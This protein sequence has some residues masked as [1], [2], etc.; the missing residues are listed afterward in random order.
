MT[1]LQELI[2]VVRSWL[3]LDEEIY[4]DHV[5]TSWIRMAEEYL[6]EVLRVKHMVQI[7]HR[8]ITDGRVMLPQDWLQL[9]TVRFYPQGKPLTYAPRHEFYEP[10]YCVD[11]RYTVVGNYI[12]IGNAT[13]GVDIEISYYQYIPSLGDDTTW[14]YRYNPRLLTLCV[15]WHASAYVIEDE[16]V[17]GWQS[18]VESMVETLNGSSRIAKSSGSILVSKRKSFG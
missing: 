15:L 14:L 1:P 16:R 9:D 5:V 10:Q 12:L 13:D 7:D 2:A 8:T 6:S 18:A 11:N 17:G 4:P 3:A